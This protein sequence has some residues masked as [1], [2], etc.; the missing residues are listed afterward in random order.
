MRFAVAGQLAGNAAK[1]FEGIERHSVEAIEG[2]QGVDSVFGMAGIIDEIE[3]LV[4][5]PVGFGE[6]DRM[7]GGQHFCEGCGS[8]PVTGCSAVDRM[9]IH[10]SHQGARGTRIRHG[11]FVAC[12]ISDRQG[13]PG[14]PRR[15][16]G[17]AALD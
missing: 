8:A 12:K 10:Q 9:N 2:A 1:T 17:Q 11:E 16:P 6:Q 15:S 4:P 7:E 3:V 5:G 14:S 13:I